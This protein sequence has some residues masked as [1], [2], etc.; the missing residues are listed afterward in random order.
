M[1]EKTEQPTSKKLRDARKKG[2]V[3]KSREVVSA[4]ILVAIFGVMVA[5][6]GIFIDEIAGMILEPAVWL[7]EPFGES[8]EGIMNVVAPTAIIVV[9]PIVAT[10]FVVAIAANLGQFGFLVS[11]E[12]V[13]P[14]LSNLS[15][16]SG[17]KKIFNRKNLVEFIKSIVKIVFLSI[18][19]GLVIRNS[20]QE[21]VRL[22]YCGQACIV[23][24]LGKLLVQIIVYTSFAYIVIAFADYV[25]QKWQ[26]NKEQMMSKDEVKREYKE[27]EGDP[28]LKGHRRQLQREIAQGDSDQSVRKSR[29][30]VTNPI[31]LA[32]AIYYQE[33]ETPL[34]IIAA[35][36][37]RLVAKRI[38]KI[39]NEA[40][41]PVFENIPVARG[42][43]FE[44]TLNQYIPSEMIEGVAEILRA[45]RDLEEERRHGD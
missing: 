2:Q 32:V 26:F 33:G 22:P 31:H 42:L 24:L 9:A 35:K 28:H 45:V 13:K 44:G 15:P 16:V 38:V 34:P 19:L 5:M 37:Q 23:P 41:I 12:S 1:T 39:A 40:G 4:A 18:L 7:G 10:A 27:S 6:M 20:L 29:V 21:L 8:V 43:F 36:G 14:K 30:V 3:G 25:F 11:F 17:V